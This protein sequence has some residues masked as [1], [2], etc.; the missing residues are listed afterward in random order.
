MDEKMYTCQEVA[1]RYKIK[2][3]TV[4]AM[5]REGRLPAMKI[6]GR[7]Y[8]FRESDLLRYEQENLVGK[9]S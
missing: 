3:K 6:N 9:K 2:L 4:W 8:R 7:N 1:D 5:V